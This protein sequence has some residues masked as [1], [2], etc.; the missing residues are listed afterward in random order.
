MAMYMREG[1]PALN[2]LFELEKDVLAK[3]ANVKKVIFF[4]I[5][6]FI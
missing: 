6:I 1:T 5:E 4:A 3:R 2:K